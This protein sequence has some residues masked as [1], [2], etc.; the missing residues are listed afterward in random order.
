MLRLPAS[1]AGLDLTTVAAHLVGALRLAGAR[2]QA[3]PLDVVLVH[4]GLPMRARMASTVLESERV[5]RAVVTHVRAAPFFEAVSIAVHPRPAL[6]APLMLADLRVGPVGRS[7]LFVDACGPGV[8]HPSF[9]RRFHDPLVRVRDA[10]PA[11]LR[12]RE[13]PEW[14][15]AASGGTGARLAAP[16]GAGQDLARVLLRYT[17]A[18]LDALAHAEAAADADDNAAKARAVAATVKKNGA[19]RRWLERSFGP[20][21]TGEY[22]RLLWNEA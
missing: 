6:E 4:G 16:R 13:V 2:T 1:L 10:H 11:S 5:A 22:E 8:A 17:D 18:Y 12:K 3:A 15:A 7:N 9:M 14:I 20:A 19:A 21:R